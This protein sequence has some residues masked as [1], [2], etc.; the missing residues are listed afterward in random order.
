MG[1]IKG[2]CPKCK[3]ELQ[4]P[5]ELDKIICMY[6]GAEIQKLEALSQNKE[7]LKD[8]VYLN[9]IKEAKKNLSEIIFHFNDPL[10]K[11]NKKE[12][13]LEFRNFYNKHEKVFV[14][15]EQLYIKSPVKEEL[16]KEIADSFLESV[17]TILDKLKNKRKKEEAL[18]NYN[19]LMA[20]YVFPAILELEGESST[21]LAQSILDGWKENFPKTNLSIASFKSINDGFNKKF[22]Y[23]TTAVCESLGKSDDCYEL[24]LLRN[25]RDAYLQYQPNGMELIKKYYDIA[26]T[27][28]KRIEKQSNSHTIYKNVW[29]KYLNPCIQCIEM[30]EKEECMKIYRN[31]VEKLEKKY[32]M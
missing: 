26:P 32:F 30:D 5:E 7:I 29:K 12:Y 23:I 28:V 27:I 8:S 9:D 1:F 19:M 22:C 17:K 15:I 31:M 20:V 21:P 13:K 2:T 11:F 24:T 16:I 25:Y 10:A 14:K 4:M 18:L 3:G 6:C